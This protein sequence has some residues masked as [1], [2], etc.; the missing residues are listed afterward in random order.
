[1]IERLREVRERLRNSL[2]FLPTVAVVLAIALGLLLVRYEVGQEGFASRLA[3]GGGSQGARAVLQVIAGSVM[4]VVSVSFSLVVVALVNASNQY[5][6]RVLSTFLR[7]RSQRIVLATFLATVAYSVVVLRTVPSVDSDVPRMAVT[8]AVLL[9]FASLAAFVH[10]IHHITQSIRVESVLNGVADDTER[11]I[12]EMLPRPADRLSAAHFPAVPDDAAALPAQTSGFV[13]AY[14]CGR[15][16][17]RARDDGLRLVFRRRVGERVTAGTTL[18]HAWPP[19]TDPQSLEELVA[20]ANGA[21]STGRERTLDQDVAFGVRQL[22]D[23]ALRAL[24]PGVNDPTTATD[25]LGRLTPVLGAL[26]QLPLGPWAAHDEDDDPRVLLPA[27]TF[28]EYLE[29]VV[30][31]VVI[32]GATDPT[33]MIALVRL[34]EDVGALC[35]DD[36]RRDLVTTHIRACAA[37]ASEHLT[38]AAARSMVARAVHEAL[39]GLGGEESPVTD[40]AVRS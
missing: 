36:E 1:M 30:P 3:F 26:A 21:V 6:P 33:A 7:D 12:A 39:E 22:V 24:S 38:E 18:A 28:A 37:A 10:F 16:A 40:S 32:Y 20:A 15:L 29:I 13:Q 8:V 4:T 2:W 19:P 31:Q 11:A 34:L 23:I 27:P 17:R 35:E 9:A 5:S 14:Y 25:A